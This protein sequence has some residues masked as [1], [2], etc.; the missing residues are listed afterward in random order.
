MGARESQILGKGRFHQSLQAHK[1]ERLVPAQ[2][3]EY[4]AGKRR[5]GKRR[6]GR[7]GAKRYAHH[8]QPDLPGPDSGLGPAEI[9]EI[10]SFFEKRRHG[11]S[12]V[13]VFALEN[14]LA[15]LEKEEF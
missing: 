10:F 14:A 4:R 5:T 7:F 3:K 12:K 8:L 9:Q 2:E 11:F 13:Y 6:F 15:F 1:K